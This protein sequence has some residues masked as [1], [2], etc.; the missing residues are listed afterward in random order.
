VATF[1]PC[2]RKGDELTAAV[3]SLIL[4]VLS[5]FRLDDAASSRSLL[6]TWRAVAPE[7]FPT[8]LDDREPPRQRLDLAVV[9]DLLA[10][11]HGSWMARRARPHVEATL[12]PGWHVHGRLW[13]LVKPQ[14]V[15][16]ALGRL[17]ELADE[18]TQ[19]LRADYGLVHAVTEREISAAHSSG[20]SDV[21]V[22]QHNP[23]YAELSTAFTK[24]LAHGLPTM[25]WR[26]YFGK[27]YVDMFGL[28]RLRAL[29]VHSVVERGGAVIIQ[30]TESPPS[31]DSW[32]E[33]EAARDRAIDSLGSEAFWPQGK[34][35]PASFEKFK[36]L[37]FVGTVPPT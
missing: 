37:A 9:S 23:F 4:G 27:P 15:P 35:S 22:V 12:M 33:F 28:H 24:E 11:D 17:A 7:L 18:L 3:K 8:H 16:V 10:D 26:N 30:L 21:V 6:E 20:R 19:L 36:P 25:Y 13:I 2:A 14:R 5:P 1:Q 31:E 34:R 29:P 32:P